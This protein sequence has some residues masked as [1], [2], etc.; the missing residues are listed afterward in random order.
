MLEQIGQA[1]AQRAQFKCSKL[2]CLSTVSYAKGKCLQHYMKDR[3]AQQSK[4]ATLPCAT[5]GCLVVAWTK[6]SCAGKFYCMA[7]ATELSMQGKH[8]DTVPAVP[9][10]ALAE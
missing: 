7:H 4:K 2:G 3:Y 8:F 9:A 5:D 1:S 6:Q 10:P